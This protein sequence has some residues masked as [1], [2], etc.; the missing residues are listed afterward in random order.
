[1]N[2]TVNRN[3]PKQPENANPPNP[4]IVN[5]FIPSPSPEAN[6]NKTLTDLISQSVN[7]DVLEKIRELDN[8]NTFNTNTNS[9][10]IPNAKPLPINTNPLRAKTGL[11][12]RDILQNAT[13]V[14]KI[15]HPS[16]RSLSHK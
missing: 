8:S 11:L 6:I 15:D 14:R 1:M 7:P 12:Y 2:Y 16:N 13:N 3:N 5:Q 9:V 4:L 10:P